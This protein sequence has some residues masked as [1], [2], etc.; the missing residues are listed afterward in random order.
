VLAGVVASG[1]VLSAVRLVTSLE[2]VILWKAKS[3]FRLAGYEGVYLA[4][5]PVEGEVV[6]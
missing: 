2:R 1:Q 5:E 4:G 3:V 6:K